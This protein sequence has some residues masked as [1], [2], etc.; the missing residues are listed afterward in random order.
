MKKK[1][2]LTFAAAA[3]AVSLISAP[4]FTYPGCTI[5]ECQIPGIHKHDGNYYSGHSRGGGYNHHGICA[6]QDCTET[7]IHE[8]DG[9]RYLPRNGTEWHNYHNNW[10]EGKGRHHE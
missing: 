1:T 6:L 8:H 10:H 2:V 4:V 3:F 5:E 9:I 7:E